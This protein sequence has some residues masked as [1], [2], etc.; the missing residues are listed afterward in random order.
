VGCRFEGRS[1]LRYVLTLQG[2]QIAGITAF[3]SLDDFGRFG[4]PGEIRPRTV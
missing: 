2:A 3:H 4:L 1:S